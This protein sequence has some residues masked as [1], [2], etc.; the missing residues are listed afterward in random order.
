MVQTIDRYNLINLRPKKAATKVRNWVLICHEQMSRP[1]TMV[2]PL[3]LPQMLNL[4]AW[5]VDKLCILLVVVV[6]SLVVNRI[7][8]AVIISEFPN[9]FHRS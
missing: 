8:K 3:I 1:L 7:Q 9:M 5:N 6:R 4:S 2:S